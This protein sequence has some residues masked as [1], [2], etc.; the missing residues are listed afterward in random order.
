MLSD[1]GQKVEVSKRWKDDEAIS[2]AED[3]KVYKPDILHLISKI[4]QLIQSLNKQ[5]STLSTTI[6][7]K[8]C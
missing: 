8:I 3:I 6:S 4:A 5:I 2:V 1:V 7:P